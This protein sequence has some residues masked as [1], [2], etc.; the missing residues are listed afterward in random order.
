MMNMWPVFGERIWKS[1]Y[2]GTLT[3]QLLDLLPQEPRPGRGFQQIR[4][5]IRILEQGTRPI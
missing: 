3:D 1:S 4:L 5:Y 2:C